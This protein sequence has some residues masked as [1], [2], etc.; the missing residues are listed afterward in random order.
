VPWLIALARK[1]GVARHIGSGANIWSNVH[2]DD[3]AELYALAL[4]KAPA[5]S[6][7]FAENG[8]NAMAETCR[9]ISRALGFGDRAESMSLQEAA[10]EWGDGAANDTMGSNSRVRAVRAR[11]ELGWTPNGPA[12]LDEIERGC[13]AAGNGAGARSG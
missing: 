9:A 2:I 4:E 7:Y 6:F 11:K 12:L 8:E 5:G 1:H 10:A 13:Y 3:L